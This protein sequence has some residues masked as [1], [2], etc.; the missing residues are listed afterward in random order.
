MV[1]NK[2]RENAKK[3]MAVGDGKVEAKLR[4]VRN[5]IAK[6][7]AQLDAGLGLPE[8]QAWGKIRRR[9]PKKYTR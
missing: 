3:S 5:K 6:G 8:K 1:D 9:S 2:E 7:V 4:Q